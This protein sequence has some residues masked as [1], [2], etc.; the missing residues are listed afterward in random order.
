MIARLLQLAVV[1]FVLHQT[2]VRW[3]LARPVEAIEPPE[4]SKLAAPTNSMVMLSCE[5]H[6]GK[7]AIVRLASS[8]YD[9]YPENLVATSLCQEDGAIA[10]EFP[11]IT[12]EPVLIRWKDS[13]IERRTLR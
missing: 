4:W 5:Y 11:W 1:L 3:W 7:L 10:V 9:T 12:N 2:A 6:Q 8:P 13:R